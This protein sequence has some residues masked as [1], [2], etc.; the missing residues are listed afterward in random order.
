MKRWAKTVLLSAALLLAALSSVSAWP[1]LRSSGKEDSVTLPGVQPA[2]QQE[3]AASEGTQEQTSAVQE[4]EA[5][6]TADTSPLSIAQA[7]TEPQRPSATSPE[8]AEA[9][10]LLEENPDALR[11]LLRGSLGDRAYERI[12]PYIDIMI[13]EYNEACNRHDA[14]AAEYNALAADNTLLVNERLGQ[15][16]DVMIVP[17][18]VY[19]I[20]GRNWGAGLSLGVS[21]KNLMLTAGAEKIFGEG[22]GWEDGYRVRLGAGISL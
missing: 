15:D 13:S 6:T 22:I 21:W 9:M 1:S 4:P 14:L 10:K 18:A 2:T 8:A 7:S 11:A 12:E 19:D 20:S 16:V 3:E 5:V 17:E